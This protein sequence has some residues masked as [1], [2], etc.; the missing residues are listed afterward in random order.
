MRKAPFPLAF[1]VKLMPSPVRLRPKQL[2]DAINDYSWRRDQELASLDAV[3]PLTLPFPEY[4]RCYAEELSRNAGE[5]RYFAIE[6]AR[7]KHIGNC[8]YYRVSHQAREAQL[9]IMIGDQAY[10]CR[11]YGTAA[12][13]QL[14]E[15]IFTTTGLERVYLRTLEANLRAQR[16]FE[17]CG[18]RRC[19]QMTQEGHSFV[20]MEIYR[21]R[22][23]ELR[24]AG[25]PQKG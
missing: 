16:C 8:M 9:G 14:L 22:W 4:L 13:C 12:V 6:T 24:K 7:G 23:Q 25:L 20:A 3:Q 17:K 1:R 2:K 5:D 15:H 18:F 19:G 10:W 11:G 21:Q